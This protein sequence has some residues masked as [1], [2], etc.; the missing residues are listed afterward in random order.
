MSKTFLEVVK[1]YSK[2]LAL[3]ETTDSK[4]LVWSEDYEKEWFWIYN[5]I[6]EGAR[7]FWINRIG[8]YGNLFKFQLIKGKWKVVEKGKPLTFEAIK[9]ISCGPAFEGVPPVLNPP[10]YVRWW[11]QWDDLEPIIQASRKWKEIQGSKLC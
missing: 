6:P 8:K 5:E 3:A 7:Y 1:S 2:N 11:A 10:D 9:R 4:V